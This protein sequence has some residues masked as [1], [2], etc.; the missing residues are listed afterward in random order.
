MCLSV[1]LSVCLC[2]C[3]GVLVCVCVVE[4]VPTNVSLRVLKP[5]CDKLLEFFGVFSAPT[6]KPQI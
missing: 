1:C 3:V 6:K 4:S 2:V 5:L